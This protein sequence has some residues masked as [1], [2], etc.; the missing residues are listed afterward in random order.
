MEMI[1]TRKLLRQ[2][3]LASLLNEGNELLAI[4]VAS[5]NTARHRKET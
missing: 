1:V 4:V 2:P 5:I 3:R